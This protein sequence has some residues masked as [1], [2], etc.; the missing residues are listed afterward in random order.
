MLVL[1]LVEMNSEDVFISNHLS[2]QFA[3]FHSLCIISYSLTINK[4]LLCYPFSSHD[5]D[6]L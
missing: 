4:L 2:I 1:E 6:H 3:H 5:I